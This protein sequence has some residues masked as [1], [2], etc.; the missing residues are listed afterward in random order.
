[1]ADQQEPILELTPF[2]LA[3][4]Q[5]LLADDQP[6]EPLED[7]FL[8]A[9]VDATP[10]GV[11][12]ILAVLRDQFASSKIVSREFSGAGFFTRLSVLPEAPRLPAA[13]LVFGNVH[14]DSPELEV[15]AG[16]ILFIEEGALS[17]LETFTYTDEMW[18]VPVSF[19]IRHP[20]WKRVG[21][22]MRIMD[23]PPQ[24]P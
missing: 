10:E 9:G 23:L 8:S 4:M 13:R 19:T 2:E 21:E 20:T 11:R 5:A 16:S 22:N 17:M 1:V 7:E 3:V 24:A 18:A 15:G 6:L 14:V 12:R